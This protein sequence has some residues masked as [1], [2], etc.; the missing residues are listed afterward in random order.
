MEAWTPGGA[1]IS[2]C[3]FVAT[4]LFVGLEFQKNES[5]KIGGKDK[6]TLST[7]ESAI[8]LKI[9]RGNSL[10]TTF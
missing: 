2:E 3:F 7:S 4:F 5:K 1:T 10:E 9:H 8:V 6:E